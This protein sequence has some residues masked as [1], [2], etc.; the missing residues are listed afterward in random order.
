MV[1]LTKKEIAVR[2]GL[3]SK[4]GRINYNALQYHFE[5]KKVLVE[6]QMTKE[7]YKKRRIPFNAVEKDIIVRLLYPK[8]A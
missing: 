5:H 7:D 6:L 8:A 2:L 4:S 1:T 3:M